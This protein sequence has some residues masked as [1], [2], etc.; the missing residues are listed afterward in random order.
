MRTAAQVQSEID[1]F[2]DIVF[3]ALPCEIFF[4]NRT[5]AR[6]DDQI[7]SINVTTTIIAVLINKLLFFIFMSV[8]SSLWS[9]VG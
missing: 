6:T 8:V 4:G 9:V 1:I 5:V 7:N 2:R 3:N